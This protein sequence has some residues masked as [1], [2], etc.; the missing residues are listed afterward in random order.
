DGNGWTIG[1]RSRVRLAR[2]HLRRRRLRTD[3]PVAAAGHS[4]EV[5][6]PV[7]CFAQSLAECRDVD[8]DVA[9]FHDK[10]GPHLR[11]KLILRHHLALRRGKHRKYVECLA[12]ELDRRPLAGKFPVTEIEPEA[13]EAHLILLHAV[14]PRPRFRTIKLLNRGI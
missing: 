5:D 14:Q 13:P 4:E 3:Q 6:W 1:K 8:L 12:L 9:F 11:H 10:P 7:S 2:R